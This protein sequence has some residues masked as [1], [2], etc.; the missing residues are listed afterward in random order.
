M[1]ATFADSFQVH[2][3]E[4]ST[5]EVGFRVQEQDQTSPESRLE[6]EPVCFSDSKG[7]FTKVPSSRIEQ[8]VVVEHVISID[9]KFCGLC[10]VPRGQRQQ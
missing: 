3:G 1:F 7:D 9:C 4:E 2:G 5:G 10:S 8:L 6:R